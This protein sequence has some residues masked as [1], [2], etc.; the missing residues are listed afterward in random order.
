[1]AGRA[2]L[3]VLILVSAWGCE[4]PESRRTRGGGAGADP[5]NVGSSVEL[6]GK[7]TDPYHGTKQV[8]SPR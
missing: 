3:L 2:L 5:K 6:H 8:D 4:S 7:K 1:M